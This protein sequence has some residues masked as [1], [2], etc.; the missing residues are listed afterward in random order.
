MSSQTCRWPLSLL[1]SWSY[2]LDL[3]FNKTR[4]GLLTPAGVH[5]SV[6][7]RHHSYIHIS[8]PYL[9]IHSHTLYS[10]LSRETRF[11]IW[12]VKPSA[13]HKNPTHSI[14]HLWYYN[15]W[16]RVSGFEQFCLSRDSGKKIALIPGSRD[17]PGNFIFLIKPPEFNI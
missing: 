14:S 12:P 4:L 6:C 3:L 1:T 11:F 9:H 17:F 13:H 15:V 7:S 2:H 16:T 8:R 5:W 10:G